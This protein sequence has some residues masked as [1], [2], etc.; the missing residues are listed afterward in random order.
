MK[1]IQQN[2]NVNHPIKKPILPRN[3]SYDKRDQHHK[4][5]NEQE[6][7]LGYQASIL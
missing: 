4:I 2:Y 3:S 6:L 7:R 5:C 1:S